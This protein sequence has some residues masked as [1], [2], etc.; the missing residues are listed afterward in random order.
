MTAA[1]L[2]LDSQ[3][4]KIGARVAATYVSIR[5]SCPSSC[6]LRGAGCYAQDGHVAFTTRRLDQAAVLEGPLSRRDV[7]E[8]EA[9]AIAPASVTGP[10]PADGKA[11]ERDGVTWI[12]CPN[13][14]RGRTCEQC[15]LCWDAESLRSRR[16][17]IAFAAHGRPRRVL[18]L[19][20]AV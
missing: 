19:A 9:A 18:Q 13:Q 7:A 12:P 20:L 6:P 8:Q 2:V 15:R 14:T 17:G 4:A 1:I 11:Y 3:N 10:H 16:T 5:A